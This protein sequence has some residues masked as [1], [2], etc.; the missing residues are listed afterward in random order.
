VALAQSVNDNG[1]MYF[2]PAFSGLF[3]PYWRPDAR[4]YELLEGLVH[5]VDGLVAYR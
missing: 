4:G 1:G 2:V 3:A 5:L